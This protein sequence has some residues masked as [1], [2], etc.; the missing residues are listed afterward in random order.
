MQQDEH[1]HAY[2]SDRIEYQVIERLAQTYYG[3][4]LKYVRE[5][6]PEKD[7]RDVTQEC[8]ARITA[9]HLP[10]GKEIKN[11]REWLYAITRNCIAD[12]YDSQKKK[13]L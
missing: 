8:F 7:A 5:K 2:I 4:I 11:E 10:G 13:P 3:E 9:S 1:S 12:Y 6:V